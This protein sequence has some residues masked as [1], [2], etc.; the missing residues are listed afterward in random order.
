VPG[1]YRVIATH[2][3]GLADTAAVVIRTPTLVSLNLSPESVFLDPGELQQFAVSGRLSNGQSTV[4]TVSYQATGGSIDGSGVYVAGSTAG[5]YRVIA[6]ASNGVADTSNVTINTSV[7]VGITVTPAL[8]S[9]NPGDT[10][11][12]TAIGTLSTGGTTS[13]TVV[14]SAT[15]GSITSTGTYTAGSTPGGFHVVATE[16]TQGV[17]DT[18]AVTIAAPANSTI[19]LQPGTTYQ[20][21]VGWEATAQ[22]GQHEFPNFR[23]SQT[24]VLD[25][26]VNELG[27][28]RVRLEFR[29]GNENSADYYTQWQQGQITKQDW[30]NTRYSP[31]N[32]NNDPFVINPSGFHFSELDVDINEVVNPMRARLAANGES[33]Y[34]NLCFVDFGGANHFQVTSSDE[35]AELVLAVFQ[36]IQSTYGWAPD[37]LELILEPDNGTPYSGGVIGNHIVAV[38]ARLAAAGFTPDFVGPSTTSMFNAPGYFDAIIAVPGA[39]GALSEISYHRYSQGTGALQQIAA[40]AA[41]HNLRTAHL[42]WI[43]ASAVQLLEDL[44]VGNNSSWSQFTIAWFTSDGSDDGGKYYVINDANPSNPVV[45]M[46]SR[47]PFLRQYMYYVRRGAVRIGTTNQSGAIEPVAF[48]NADGRYVVVVRAGSAQNFTVGGLPGGTYGINYSTNSQ[49]N[50]DQSDV[51]ISAGTPLAASI[52]AA[53]VITIYRK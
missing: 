32:D 21:M 25:R 41:T 52:P 19:M 37:A 49:S 40:R 26:T 33:L 53:G 22:I 23:N 51:T 24:E 50:V 48:I 10:R 20:T 15:G 45:N 6:T 14:W 13:V 16:Q 29:A 38:Q 3:S 35:Y 5:T 7:I 39:L 9:L 28:N 12:F 2:Q 42:E 47:T 27:I 44:T 36:H 17:T 46:G 43:G 8:T 18:A 31:V 4:P 11:T 1:T 34:V 30:K